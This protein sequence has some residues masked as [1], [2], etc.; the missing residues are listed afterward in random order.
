VHTGG[1]REEM[2]VFGISDQTSPKFWIDQ[3]GGGREKIWGKETL[4]GFFRMRT[5]GGGVG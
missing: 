2:G 1:I 3:N 5:T 4:E